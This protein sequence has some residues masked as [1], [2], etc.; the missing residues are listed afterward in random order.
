MMNRN[1]NQ[2]YIIFLYL[3]LAIVYVVGMFVPLMENDSAQHATMAMRMVLENDFINLYRGG[4]PYLDKPHFHF[5]ISAISFKIFGITHFAYRIPALIFTI[6]G[7]ISCY[8]LAKIIYSKKE[9]VVA[10]LVFLSSQAI[11]ISTSDLRTDAVLTGACALSIWQLILYIEKKRLMNIII[12]SIFAGIAFSTKGYLGLSVI[13]ICITTHL[14]Y[15][16]DIKAIWNWK[17]LIGLFFLLLSITPVV[18]AYYLQFDANPETLINGK[19]NVSGVKFI[20]WDHVFNR[21]NAKGFEPNNSDFLFFFHSL[22]WAFFPWA[23]LMYFAMF[24]NIKLFFKNKFKQLKNFEIFSSI[25]ILIVLILISI[26][27]FKLPHYLNSLYPVLSVLVAGYLVNLSSSDNYKYTKN[28]I[29][30][31][32]CVGVL[33][34]ALVCFVSFWAFQFSNFFLISSLLF[35]LLTLVV[36]SILKLKSNHIKVVFIAVSFS[37][38]A[39]ICLYSVFY[40]NL[41]DY[42]AGN[43]AVNFI[44]KNTINIDHVYKIESDREGFSFDFY[45]KRITPKIKLQ[46]IKAGQYLMVY[47]G[48]IEKVKNNFDIEIIETFDNYRITMIKYNFLDP[49]KRNDVLERAY[50][51]KVM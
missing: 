43:M 10:S 27:K 49:N 32:S 7:A 50:L 23:V 48:C 14:F 33:S 44:N 8:G 15:K 41:L 38:L 20:L 3:L 36:F 30:F 46:D 4:E 21:L 45:S 1:Q 34:F 26:S 13:F 2:F 22:L 17:V 35:C 12:G 16:R 51:I 25:G 39:N 9:G 31:Q 19:T 28:W 47:D 42:Q 40:P 6:I 11:I 18:Y 29:Y 5:W 24:K 37:A